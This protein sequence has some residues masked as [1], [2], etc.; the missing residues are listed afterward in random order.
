[1]TDSTPP[2]GSRALAGAFTI[3]MAGMSYD[4]DG[5]KIHHLAGVELLEPSGTPQL[6]SATFSYDDSGHLGYIGSADP[7]TAVNMLASLTA[8]LAMRVE[9]IDQ[10]DQ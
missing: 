8:M 10:V 3:T 1:M 7:R 5:S 9:T 6:V 2:P 4:T